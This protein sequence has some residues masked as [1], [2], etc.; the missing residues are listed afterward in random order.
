MR[1]NGWC[2]SIKF[3]GS[4]RMK[5]IAGIICTA[6]IWTLLICPTARAAAPGDFFWQVRSDVALTMAKRS[7]RLILV[8]VG[9]DY[10]SHCRQM[11]KKCWV[12]PKIH[13]LINQHY[14]P[15]RLDAEKQARITDQMNI[16]SLPTTIIYGSDG[17]HIARRAGYLTPDEL[18][19]FLHS[20][21][22]RSGNSPK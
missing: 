20:M 13:L 2:R 18:A 5:V 15:L 14:I 22:R 3:W 10:C 16:S 8:Y 11:D 12:D 7:N 19:E 9:A 1:K 21:A 4:K 6:F 17:R